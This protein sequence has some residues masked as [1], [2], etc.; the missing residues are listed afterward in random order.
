MLDHWKITLSADT[1]LGK[2]T[3]SPIR[4]SC[5]QD[6]YHPFSIINYF[7]TISIFHLGCRKEQKFLP[8]EH[9]SLHCS[10]KNNELE[11][12]VNKHAD[13]QT[14]NISITIPDVD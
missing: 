5:H 11:V 9:K 8:I 10:S 1:F 6:N 4:V 7:I 3:A 12:S 13:D 2:M 14:T